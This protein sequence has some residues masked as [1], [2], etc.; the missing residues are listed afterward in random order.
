[1]SKPNNDVSSKGFPFVQAEPSS[2]PLLLH[3]PMYSSSS[4][5]FTIDQRFVDE[6]KP[7]LLDN[8]VSYSLSCIANSTGLIHLNLFVYQGE[9]K[10]TPTKDENGIDVYD[11][12]NYTAPVQAVIGMAGFTLDKFNRQNSWS[13]SRISEYG[14]FR[15]HA[16][17]EELKLE[18][19]SSGTRKVEDSFRIIRKKKTT[20]RKINM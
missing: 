13:I 18:F 11:H 6:V 3:R 12:S 15:G 20:I 1:M 5:L 17:K 10:G 8:K 9:C 4:G 7:L 2:E 16:T 14:Y 19:V